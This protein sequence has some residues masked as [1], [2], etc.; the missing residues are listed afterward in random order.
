[1][2]SDELKKEIVEILQAEGLEKAEEMA[3]IAVNTTCKLMRLLVPKISTTASIMI[4]PFLEI[5][6][7]KV[8][9]K[10]DEID[11]VDSPDY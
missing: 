7:A 5:M 10:I 11:G 2:L 8:L 9:R 3:V 6:Q 4:F 1:M